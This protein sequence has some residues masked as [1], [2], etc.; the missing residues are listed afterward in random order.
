MTAA[1]EIAEQLMEFARRSGSRY[2]LT[3]AHMF[4]GTSFYFRGELTQA[5]QDFEAGIASYNETDWS[6][7]FVN[8]HVGMLGRISEVLWH[9]GTADQA[10]AKIRESISLSESLKNP[11]GMSGA[12]FLAGVLYIQLREPGNVQEVAE[13][14]LTLA[15]E[16][17]PA[18]VDD[19]SVYRGW[20]MAEQGRTDEGIALIRAGLDSYV[21]IG[22]RSDAFTLRLLSEAQARAGQLEEALATIEQ[23][24][25]SVGEKQIDLPGVL[26]W[27]GELHLRRGDE[28]K[29]ACDFREAIRVARRIGSKAYEL[30]AITSLARLL[31]KQGR[32]EEARAML[33]DIY[34]WFSEGFD[35]ADL[36][37]AKT[38]LD[39]LNG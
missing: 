14:L 39:E 28:T 7:P 2:G 15:S 32:H 9:F 24:F 19:A 21:T 3:L 16:Q 33:A 4:Q 23:A 31:A 20:A 22:F 27:R 35:T 12:L 17:H 8:P 36:K 37:E 26:W 5:M 25:S 30:R 13:R 38:L 6:G 29:S 10:R 34:G 11:S 1:Q 18:F